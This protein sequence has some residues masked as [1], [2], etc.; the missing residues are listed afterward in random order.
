MHVENHSK[1]FLKG[2]L[3]DVGAETGHSSCLFPLVSGLGLEAEVGFTSAIWE[4]L[5]IKRSNGA[6]R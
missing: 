4:I 3:M 1:H 2:V 6:L 5:F